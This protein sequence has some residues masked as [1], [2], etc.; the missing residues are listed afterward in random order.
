MTKYNQKQTFSL[1]CERYFLDS[2]FQLCG[3]FYSP[4]Q[5]TKQAFFLN[6]RYE[7]YG[8]VDLPNMAALLTYA[9]AA[10]RASMYIMSIQENKEL[11]EVQ[12]VVQLGIKPIQM[13]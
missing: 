3:D 8:K 1:A 11:A 7:R 2:C 13:P 10:N 6:S 5:H 12:E 9:P 4:K